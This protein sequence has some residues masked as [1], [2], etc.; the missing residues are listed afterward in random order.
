MMQEKSEGDWKISLSFLLSRYV[1]FEC[2][3]ISFP[4]PFVSLPRGVPFMRASCILS[5]GEF[6]IVH[7]FIA[8]KTYQKECMSTEK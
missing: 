7:N 2:R 5:S 6:R 3:A 8:A 4:F 1:H